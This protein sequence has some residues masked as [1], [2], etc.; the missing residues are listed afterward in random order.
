M[1]ARCQSQYCG[2][3]QNRIARCCVRMHY[4]MIREQRW[5]HAG[6]RKDTHVLAKTNVVKNTLRGYD[7]LWLVLVRFICTRNPPGVLTGRF[8]DETNR[9]DVPV[10]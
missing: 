7:G 10:I 3:C 9:R 8:V 2:P 1:M 5:L 4:S 6:E